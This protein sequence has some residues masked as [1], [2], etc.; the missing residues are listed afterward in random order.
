LAPDIAPVE[1]AEEEAE[2]ATPAAVPPAEESEASTPAIELESMTLSSTD[3]PV[4]STVVL[5]ATLQ[6]RGMATGE[7]EVIAELDGVE[8]G[9]ASVE[10]DPGA[11]EEVSLDIVCG[12]AGTHQVRVG[13]S[14]ATL[15]VVEAAS[16][17]PEYE[18]LG[19]DDGEADGFAGGRGYGCSVRFT[20]PA[21]PFRV[22]RVKVYGKTYGGGLEDGKLE[23]QIRG[24]NWRRLDAKV[25]PHSVFEE[26]PEWVVFEMSGR[27][28][29]EEF[30]VVV[31]P[32]SPMACGVTLGIDK[33]SEQ[34]RSERIPVATWERGPEA[35]EDWDWMIRVEQTAA[36]VLP[37][38][39]M[40]SSSPG[41]FVEL[42]YDDGESDGRSSC[43]GCGYAVRFTPPATPFVVERVRIYGVAYGGGCEGRE[44]EVL[45]RSLKWKR[46]DGVRRPHN[47]FGT[48]Y[49]WA[50]FE[51]SGRKV[52]EAFYVVVDL[53]APFNCS[54][55][56]GVDLDGENA[57]SE[58]TTGG[59]L[60]V[61]SH[62]PPKDET[63]WMI[64]VEGR[65]ASGQ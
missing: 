36:P 61:W 58:K 21:T 59:M 28:V 43:N 48:E 55:W 51:M 57:G 1:P 39:D 42:K 2:A 11:T 16:P 8:V 49:E 22:E 3:V 27:V 44:V 60:D 29:D 65:V 26:T 14:T 20:P 53:D 12:A 33:D 17:D 30:Y 18:E 31:I 7:Y 46:L 34:E 47:V 50:T 62:G 25:F 63:N 41:G 5:T 10:V 37:G 45:I 19:Y 40:T 6:N 32:E 56:M 35:H 54:V 64:R 24:A 4:G 38:G 52:N 15:H 9:S 13:G 23:I